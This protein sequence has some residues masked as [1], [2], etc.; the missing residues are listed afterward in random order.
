MKRYCDCCDKEVETK[1]ISRNESFVVLNEN[2]EVEAN[3]LICEEC[4][5]ELFCEELDEA[6]LKNAY[7]EYRKKHRL[8]LPNEISD[9]RKQYGLSQRSFANLLNWGDKTICR[10]ENGSIQDKA[11]N[12]LL[13]FL[14]DPNN[15]QSYLENNEINIS[16]NQKA[17]IISRIE[18]MKDT[19]FSDLSSELLKSI[20]SYSP[21]INNGFKSFDYEKFCAMVVYFS[22]KVQDLLKVKL[23][24][25]LNYADMIFYKENGVSISGTEYVHLP[26][27]PVPQNFDMLFGMMNR[28]GISHIEIIYN[29]QYECHQVVP[30]NR[31]FDILSVEETEVLDRVIEKFATYSSQEISEYSHKEKGYMATKQG[32]IISYDYAKDIMF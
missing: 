28:D 27:G 13:V 23:L 26:F 31:S 21:S 16:E 2:I 10:Y 20:F 17:R 5:E 29:G 18:R 9:I 6:T 8:L 32:D 3:V 14:R 15:M 11:H 22:S 1:V 7:N 24:K 4:G 12:S 30:D 19:S 25:L